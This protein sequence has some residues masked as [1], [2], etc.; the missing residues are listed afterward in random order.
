MAYDMASF[1]LLIVRYANNI[2]TRGDRVHGDEA[3]L[4]RGARPPAPVRV[5]SASDPAG[6]RRVVD[7]L[8]S[9]CASVWASR[10]HPL[11]VLRRSGRSGGG[12]SGRLRKVG[13][14]IPEARDLLRGDHG[15]A[16]A[17]RRDD[18][19]GVGRGLLRAFRQ[20]AIFSVVAPDSRFAD[21]RRRINDESRIARRP[22][23][24][25]AILALR[26]RGGVVGQAKRVARGHRRSALDRRSDRVDSGVELLLKMKNVAAIFAIS[27][28]SRSSVHNLE[29][30]KSYRCQTLRTHF[31]LSC[32][33]ST[34][35][36]GKRSSMNCSG[37]F[38]PSTAGPR[39]SGSHSSRSNFTG[40]WPI[41]TTPRRRREGCFSKAGTVWP[42]RSIRRRSLCTATVTGPT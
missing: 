6:R 35:R 9:V 31:C 34:T 2:H 39:A 15:V 5:N 42:I 12:G 37:R 29:I 1:V 32:I 40:R 10:L 28:Y 19:R 33:S 41:R 7:A 27:N 18:E 24:V 11:I 14:F 13:P 38:I 25:R 16:W 17:V 8:D 20:Y 3:D 4:R 36:I 26:H 21:V 22:L 30:R 23:G